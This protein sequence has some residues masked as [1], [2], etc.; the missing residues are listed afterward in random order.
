MSKLQHLRDLLKSIDDDGQWKAESGDDG[1]H[2]R[3][4]R[5]EEFWTLDGHNPNVWTCVDPQD[6][7][8]DISREWMKEAELIA[9]L[10]NAAPALIAVVEA[11]QFALHN[12]ELTLDCE[13]CE[14]N[15][16]AVNRLGEALAALDPDLL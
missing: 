4:E 7:C 5:R 11:A 8:W 2:I 16:A 1:P 9:A 3:M 13:S 10:R 12:I 14:Q 15:E 6:G